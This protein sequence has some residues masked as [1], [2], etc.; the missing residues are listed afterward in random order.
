[1][2]NE[3]RIYTAPEAEFDTLDSNDV[4]LISVIDANNDMDQSATKWAEW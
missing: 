4:V 3:K 1:M 2:M